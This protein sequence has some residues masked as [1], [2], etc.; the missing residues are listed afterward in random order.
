MYVCVID[1]ERQK[2][3]QRDIDIHREIETVIERDRQV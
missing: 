3:R 2:D 1:R